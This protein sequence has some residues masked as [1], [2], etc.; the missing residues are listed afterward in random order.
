MTIGATQ[1]DRTHAAQHLRE[2]ADECGRCADVCTETVTHCLELGGRYA[3]ALHVNLLLDCVAICRASATFL[4]HGT[5]RHRLTCYVAAE[6]CR[7]C[8]EDCERIG[9]GDRQMLACAEAC[10]RCAVLCEEMAG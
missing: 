9:R 1:E 3:E 5:P 2:C 10:R 4:R 8:A 7:A 6:V